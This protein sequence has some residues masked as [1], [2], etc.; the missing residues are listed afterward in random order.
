M[1]I[2][3]SIRLR[4]KKRL[5]NR[6]AQA[7]R[8]SRPQGRSAT[9]EAQLSRR[10][11]RIG[12][13]CLHSAGPAASPES[14]DPQS[15]SSR[16]RAGSWQ[17]APPVAGL[18]PMG[19]YLSTREWL[20]ASG[21]RLTGHRARSAAHVWK[22]PRHWPGLKIGSDPPRAGGICREDAETVRESHRRSDHV[23]LCD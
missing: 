11:R 19:P 8:R 9:F 3:I 2:R 14:G 17:S 7:S 1:W 18:V 4:S 23:R 6:I 10:F 20:R 5:D 22:M 15:S 12:P 13:S 21:T 16:S